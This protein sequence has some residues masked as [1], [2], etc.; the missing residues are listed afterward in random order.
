MTAFHP[1]PPAKAI[2]LVEAA[3]I[4]NA[5]QLIRDFAAAGLVKSYALVLETIEPA[6]RRTCVRGGAIPTG[7]WQRIVGDGVEDAAWIGGAVWLAGADLIGGMPAAIIT[8][9]GFNDKDL[10]RLIEHQQGGVPKPAAAKK[11]SVVGVEL[12]PELQSAESPKRQPDSSA[13][14]NG[15]LLATV[16]QVEAALGFG[17]TKVN[18]LI[19]AGRLERVKIDGGV[20]ITVASVKALAVQAGP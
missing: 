2:Q 11:A 5:A 1:V 6:G 9:I 4:S 7:L 10:Q 20:R 12:V 8:G 13:I 18:E 14:P 15:A 16:R 17:R 3:G 19:N